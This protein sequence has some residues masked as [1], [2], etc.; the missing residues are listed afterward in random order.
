MQR[1]YRYFQR[2]CVIRKQVYLGVDWGGK[3][4]TPT[5]KAGNLTCVVVISAQQDGT[6][7][8]EHAH[9]LKKNFFL[10]DTIKEMY[11]R[12]G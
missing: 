10:K 7:L 2:V 12:L 5:L 9:K 8:V 3:K 11:R 1:S 4:M 6:L